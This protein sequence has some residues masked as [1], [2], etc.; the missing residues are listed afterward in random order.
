MFGGPRD[1]ACKAIIKVE[2]LAFEPAFERQTFLIHCAP[3]AVDP[4]LGGVAFRFATV[5]A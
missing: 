5:H 4:D 2:D 1:T 3:F